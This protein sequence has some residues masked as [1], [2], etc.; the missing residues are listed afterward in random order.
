MNKQYM[1]GIKVLFDAGGQYNDRAQE[2]RKS[3]HC[4]KNRNEEDRGGCSLSHTR[5]STRSYNEHTNFSREIINNCFPTNTV[6]IGD[7]K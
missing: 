1:K 3:N 2:M 5:L 6:I 4:S 7:P